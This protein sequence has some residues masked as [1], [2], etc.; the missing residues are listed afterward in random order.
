MTKSHPCFDTQT[1]KS[2]GRLHLPVAAG[3]NARNRFDDA[4]YL[5]TLECKVTA[6]PT[7]ISPADALA[8]L[9]ATLER[10]VAV[11]VV[12]ITGPGEPFAS[13]PDL[14]RSAA[15]KKPHPRR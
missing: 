7:A 10:D 4:Q 2:T 12:G 13:P 14:L 5:S 9:A 1:R 8:F 15:R 6:G 11:Q 3:T